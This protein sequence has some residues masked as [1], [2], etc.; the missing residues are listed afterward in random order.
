MSVDVWTVLWVLDKP[1]EY[2][3][4]AASLPKQINPEVRVYTPDDVIRFERMVKRHLPHCTFRCLSN[5]PVGGIETIPLALPINRWWS[6]MEVFRPDLITSR[7]RV[8]RNIYF[9]LDT[10]LI[11]DLD[12]IVNFPAPCAFIKP[13]PLVGSNRPEPWKDQEGYLRIPRYQCSMKVWDTEYGFK[14]W[15]GLTE[16]HKARLASD[17]DFLAESFPAEARMPTEWFRKIGHAKVKPPKP[18]KV[19]MTMPTRNDEAARRY[20]WVREIWTT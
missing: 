14:F 1:F 13:G 5:V 11:R 4:R 10:I 2:R 17:Q 7:G 15:L 12:E 16:S 6:Q 9:D 19:V 18:V 20:P 8:G 3:S